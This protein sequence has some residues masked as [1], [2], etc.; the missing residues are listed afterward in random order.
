MTTRG[1]SGR[2]PGADVARRLPPGQYQ[3]SDFPVLAV[4]SSRSNASRT[5]RS[6]RSSTMSRERVIRWMFAGRSA[7]ISSGASKMVGLCCSSPGLRGRAA[8]GDR[9]IP[10][11]QCPDDRGIADL[12][13]PNVGRPGLRDEL[14]KM[15]AEN[16]NLA[17]VLITTRGPRH[18]TEDF[19]RRLDRSLLCEVSTHW[20][21]VA[22]H[23]YVCGSNAFVESATSSLVLDG[24]PDARIRTERFG[25]EH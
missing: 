22:R 16:P 14:L 15:Q 24:V 25:G 2:R 4:S 23:A 20:G 13:C 11:A 9:G 21:R 1:F 6:R 12:L 8:D 18:R 17:I 10:G 5:A 7:A 3:T 19:E